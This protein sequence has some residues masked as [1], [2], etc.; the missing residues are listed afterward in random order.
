MVRYVERDFLSVSRICDCADDD[1]SS[2]GMSGLIGEIA[3]NSLV[4]AVCMTGWSSGS[5]HFTSYN[6]QNTHYH[7]FFTQQ[8]K[9][10]LSYLSH[11]KQICCRWLKYLGKNK[12]NIFNHFPHTTNLQQR[13]KNIPEQILNLETPFKW[14]YNNWIEFKTWWQNEKCSFWTISSFVDMFWIRCLLQRRQKASIWGKGLNK[15]IINK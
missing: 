13:T 11:I 2:V 6:K 4:T 8:T 15:S 9:Y 12:G 14:K 1:D 5:S 7:T 3:W 10:P